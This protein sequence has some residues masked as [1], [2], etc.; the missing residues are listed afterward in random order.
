VNPYTKVVL[1]VIRLVAFGLVFTSLLYLSS[2]LFFAV[3]R[4]S[5]GEGTVSLA[6]KS[7]PL[8]LG[9]ILWIKSHALAKK[10]TEDF[11]D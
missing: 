11:D 2:Y 5:S 8:I 9:I 10:L 1:F 4:E 6:L 7:L 3:G